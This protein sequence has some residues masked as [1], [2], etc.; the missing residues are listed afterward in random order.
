MRRRT[1]HPFGHSTSGMRLVSMLMAILVLWMFYERLKDPA[2]WRGIINDRELKA[3]T[4]PADAP[5]AP[6][7][8]VPGPNDLD[9]D[10][11]AAIQDQFEAIDDRAP[12]KPREM[13]AYWRLMGWSVTQPF[14]ELEQRAHEDVSFAQLWEQPEKHRGKLIRL[15]LHIRRVLDYDAPQNPLGTAKVFE[16]WGWSD[17]SLSF[18][19]V[20]VMPEKPEQ[21]PMGHE[22]RGE[23]VFVGYFFKIMSYKAFDNARG[24]PLLVGRARMASISKP[25]PSSA[26]DPWIIPLVVIGGTLFIGFTI[27]TGIRSHGKS[28][29]KMLPNELSLTDANGNFAVEN[30]FNQTDI[31]QGLVDAA[32]EPR[33][34]GTAAEQSAPPA[35]DLKT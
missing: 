16:A 10:E 32:V 9:P 35:T 1:A 28:K 3:A 12:L 22:M 18:P 26:L 15:R 30:P 33:V 19:Y 24:A 6:E 5:S 11:F 31:D 25:A 14:A 29:A 20:V 23:V 17:E 7:N 13:D 2:T 8:L 4:P 34:V 27:F 21:L